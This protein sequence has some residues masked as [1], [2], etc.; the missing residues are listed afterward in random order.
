MHHQKESVWSHSIK[1]SFLSF[2]LAKKL[3]INTYNV[4]IAGLLHDFYT[5]AWQYS[6]ELEDLDDIYKERFIKEKKLKS[7]AIYHPIESLNNSRKYFENLLNKRVEDAIV[8]HMFPLSL[9]TKYKIPKYKESIIIMI[10]D[11]YV[12][13]KILF[14]PKI[15][16]ESIKNKL[17]ISK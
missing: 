3:Q 17:F 1:V 11:R 15:F 4:I 12:S 2:K 10:V 5:R 8:K 9:F 7:H 6:F 16:I 13:L 14:Q